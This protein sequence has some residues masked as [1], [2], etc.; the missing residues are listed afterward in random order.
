MY[1][2][3]RQTQK[4]LW[5]EYASV[6][7]KRERENDDALDLVERHSLPLLRVHDTVP[8]MLEDRGKRGR[9]DAGTDENGDL[10]PKDVFACG[11]EGTVDLRDE[12]MLSRGKS[13]RRRGKW[14]TMIRGRTRPT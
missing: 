6:K 3:S 13:G 11:A 4:K 14:R 10:E 12:S 8:D 5:C 1:G 2:Q 7:V 9:A